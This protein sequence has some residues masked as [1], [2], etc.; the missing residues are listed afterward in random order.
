MKHYGKYKVKDVVIISLVPKSWSSYCGGEYPNYLPFPI[1]AKIK[2]IKKCDSPEHVA[3][4]MI[5]NGKEFG[6]SLST[7][8]NE[9]NIKHD[10]VQLRKNKLSELK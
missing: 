5:Y 1:K 4:L 6:F 3:A 8:I 2:E 9:N 7:L 10:I